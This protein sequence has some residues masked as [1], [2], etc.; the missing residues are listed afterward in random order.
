MIETLDQVSLHFNKDSLLLLNACIAFIMFGVALELKIA[1]FKQL[2][3]TPKP[4]LVGLGS[5]LIL[6]PMV[7]FGLIYIIDPI[8]SVAL[9]MILVASCPGGNVSNFYTS[10]SK[11]NVAL[12]VS[13][14]ALV[15]SIAFF[16][17]PFNFAFWAGMYKPTAELLEKVDMNI[18][19][20]I[21]TVILILAVP[22]TLGMIF[23]N[24]FPELT[25]KITKPIKRLSIIIFA[26]FV[27][28]ALSAN[29]EQF[30]NHILEVIVLV[31][32]HNIIALSTGFLSAKAFNLSEQDKRSITI[33]TGIQNT[34][35][36]L[37]IIFD[38][39]DGLGG[40]AFIAAWWG[41]WHLISGAG[42]SWYWSNQR[43]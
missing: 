3:Q 26:A 42:I 19:N 23:N 2:F 11:G 35:I 33:E 39:F 40:M 17:T 15:S 32:L 4:I 22:L 21:T 8:P 1:H 38:F 28:F 37:V 13:L 7:T 12:S 5:Q 10:M 25:K 16:M 41:I 43:Y 30:I 36:A 27:V 29:F 20:V 24:H 34:G 14:T 18:W 6:M 9:G 31:F